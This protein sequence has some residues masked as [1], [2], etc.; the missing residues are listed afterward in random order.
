MVYIIDLNM[1]LV[2]ITNYLF[3]LYILLKN[4]TVIIEI[5]C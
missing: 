1:Y 5:L 3:F 2:N 4:K